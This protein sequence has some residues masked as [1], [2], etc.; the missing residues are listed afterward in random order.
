MAA[1][2]AEKGMQ[3]EKDLAY[4]QF[5]RDVSDE[6]V[7]TFNLFE[8]RKYCQ[9]KSL[10]TDTHAV[11]LTFVVVIRCP[12][13]LSSLFY[14][15]NALKAENS[16]ICDCVLHLIM[17]FHRRLQDHSTSSLVFAIQ[18][19]RGT[20]TYDYIEAYTGMQLVALRHVSKK[21]T[22]WHLDLRTEVKVNK[23][24]RYSQPPVILKRRSTCLTLRKT[25]T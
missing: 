13:W 8:A 1:P 10:V 6:V 25:L 14:L 17:G 19:E 24:V 4:F 12:I 20:I 7:R 16:L 9:K 2:L 18:S 3:M 11:H 5:N 23:Q 15:A 22:Q 21:L